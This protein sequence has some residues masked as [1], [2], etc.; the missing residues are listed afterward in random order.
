MAHPITDAA[1]KEI[2]YTEK[3]AN[4]NKTKFGEW[5]GWNGVAWC[6]I[7]VS[8]CYDKG[9]FPLGNIGWLKGFAGCQAG[10]AHFVK[11]KRITTN[12]VEGD[13]VFFD[14]N[15]D[16]RFDHV[17]IFVRKIDDQYFES[18]EGNTSATNQSNGGE[19]QIR[20]RK[21]TNVVFAH[22]KCLDK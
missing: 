6:A 18:I 16:K 12:P 19:V 8:W 13:I 14:W 20:K 7:F 5:F 1:R 15:G 17:G 21:Y 11:T 22:P 2:G 4:S 3:P 9:G 10:W